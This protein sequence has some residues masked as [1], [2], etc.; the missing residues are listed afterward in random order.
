MITAHSPF[1]K[2]MKV[3]S[4]YPKEL[5]PEPILITDGTGLHW[6]LYQSEDDPLT[7][8]E[9]DSLVK[10]H[11]NPWTNKKYV[12]ERRARNKEWLIRKLNTMI[13]I[14]VKSDEP[15]TETEDAN[16]ALHPDLIIWY[17][18]DSLFLSR[19]PIAL[20][21]QIRDELNHVQ[22]NST[23]SSCTFFESCANTTGVI[24][25]HLLYPN[26]TEDKSTLSLTLGDTR[27]ISVSITDISGKTVKVICS[28]QTF[29]AGSHAIGVSLGGLSEGMYLLLIESEQGEH[30]VQRVVK[31]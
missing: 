15:Y 8:A 3:K 2:P 24:T 25:G 22:S 20:A 30:I 1:A 5:Y 6:R 31:K 13:A 7:L 4:S 10:N 23:G 12:Q 16:T 27:N 11:I 17:I 29:T 9:K 18:P 14:R 21:Q 19:L 28:K 26:P